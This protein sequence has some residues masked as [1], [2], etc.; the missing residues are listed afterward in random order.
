[1]NAALA[2]PACSTVG[3]A[4]NRFCEN[5]GHD[6]E[7]PEPVAAESPKAAP[8][9]GDQPVAEVDP[10]AAHGWELVVGTDR[11][12]YDSLE[13][14]DVAFPDDPA[15][16][17][18]IALCGERVEIGRRSESRGWTPAVDLAGPP[19]DSGISHAHAVLCRLPDGRWS[20]TDEGSANGTFLNTRSDP[21]P[22]GIATPLDDGDQ[23]HIGAWTTLTIRKADRSDR[24][25]GGGDRELDAAG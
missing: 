2:C 3:V 1:M 13:S 18:L 8:P 11:S 24:D 23:V 15:A 12:F 5:C 16:D 25:A 6:F 9:D 19:V 22:V 21:I 10:L 4:G 20:V 7:S 17:R 14:T